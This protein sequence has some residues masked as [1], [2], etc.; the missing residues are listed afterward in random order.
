MATIVIVDDDTQLR[1]ALVL[2]LQSL[3]HETVD[4]NDAAPALD[5][6][7]NGVDLVIVDFAMPTSG[8]ILVNSL[9]R[10]GF[11]SPILTISGLLTGQEQEFLLAIGATEIL[12]KPFD[13]THFTAIVHRLCKHP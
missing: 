4:F 13:L 12:L 5:H 10:S 11:L 7:Y 9:R 2:I 8:D 1:S 3:G 6:D